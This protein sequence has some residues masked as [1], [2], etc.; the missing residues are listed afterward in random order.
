[1]QTPIMNILI[2]HAKMKQMMIQIINLY[3]LKIIVDCKNI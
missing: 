2:T 3:H 1:M